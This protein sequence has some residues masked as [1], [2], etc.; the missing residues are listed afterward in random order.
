MARKFSSRNRV[1]LCG[2][3]AHTHSSG[4]AQGL[5]TGVHDAV[6]LSWKLALELRGLCIPQVIET[7]NDERQSA[8]T[9]LLN[10]DKDISLLMT[11]KWPSW[12]TGDRNADPNIVL[13]KILDESSPF[14]TGLGISYSQNIL[15]QISSSSS[16]ATAATTDAI[17][18]HRVP[19]TQLIMPCTYQPVRLHRVTHNI[20]K[21]WVIIFAGSVGPTILTSLKNLAAYLLANPAFASHE[22]I[23][24]LTIPALVG[25]SSYE[26]LGL[27][28]F[29]DTYYDPEGSA[30]VRYGI[31]QDIGGIVVTRP[32]GLVAFR[33]AIDGEEVSSY[34]SRFLYGI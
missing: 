6:N 19:D 29:G 31:E 14:N 15:N 22:A 33:C 17:P 2:D 24:W 10:Y 5:N 13:G 34:F 18:G 1:F 4:A 27:D 21:F 11:N 25:C 28:P 16:S 8:V 20:C 12:Y 23:A 30:H 9:R 7:Y 26:A 3:S 32:D